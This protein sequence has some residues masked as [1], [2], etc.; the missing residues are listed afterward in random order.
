MDLKQWHRLD[1]TTN[2]IKLPVKYQQGQGLL[3]KNAKFLY[4]KFWLGAYLY[5]PPPHTPEGLN[6]VQ[7]KD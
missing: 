2:N 3:I 6:E 4:L 7:P 5:V 1:E